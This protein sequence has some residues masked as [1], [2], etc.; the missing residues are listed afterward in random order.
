MPTTNKE[1]SQFLMC[2]HDL[3][4]RINSSSI[5]NPIYTQ[6]YEKGYKVITMNG[7]AKRVTNRLNAG[8]DS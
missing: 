4:L 2:R 1:A 5:A 3:T 6:T 8:V 7:L